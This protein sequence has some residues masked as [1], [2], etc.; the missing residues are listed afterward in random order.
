MQTVRVKR[1]I[2]IV[3]SIAN[4]K[5]NKFDFQFCMNDIKIIINNV[6]KGKNKMKINYYNEH[7]QV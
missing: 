7:K 4:C 2:V 1:L 3:L 6:N 5:Q